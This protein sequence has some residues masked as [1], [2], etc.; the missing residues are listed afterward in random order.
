MSILYTRQVKE[1]I[2]ESSTGLSYYILAAQKYSKLQAVWFLCYFMITNPW[3]FIL[4]ESNYQ[5]KWA[6]VTKCQTNLILAINY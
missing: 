5:Q 1:L 2:E 3:P 4:Y 6:K